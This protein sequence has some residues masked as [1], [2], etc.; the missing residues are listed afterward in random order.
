M[1][2]PGVFA[3]LFCRLLEAVF[4]FQAQCEESEATHFPGAPKNSVTETSDILK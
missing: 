1:L 2:P 3:G 4:I